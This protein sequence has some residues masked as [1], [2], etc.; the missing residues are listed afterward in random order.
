MGRI[1][2]VAYKP[3]DSKEEELRSFLKTHVDILRKEGLATNREQI[4]MRSSNSTYIEVFEWE[5]TEAIQK[6]HSNPAVLKMWEAFEQCGTYEK[7]TDLD[8]TH[9]MFAEFDAVKV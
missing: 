3:K 7:L 9:Q 4:V 1:V 8:E 2:I 6:A 5:S